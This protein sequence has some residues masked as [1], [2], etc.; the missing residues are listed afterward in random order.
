M[1]K[2]GGYEFA[3]RDIQAGFSH[4]LEHFSYLFLPI[5]FICTC[6]SEGILFKDILYTRRSLHYIR[7]GVD[8]N[9]LGINRKF[10]EIYEKY[11]S[12]ICP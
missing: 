6:F 4:I 7:F 8:L 5:E 9:F 2:L 1:H 10:N 11:K 12:L 3:I